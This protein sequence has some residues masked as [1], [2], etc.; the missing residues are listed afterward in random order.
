M[1]RLPIFF[2]VDVSESMIG[3]PI[4]QVQDGV[5]S[6]INELRMDPYALETAFVSVIAFAGKAK[7]LTPLT[8]LYKFYPPKFPIGGGTSLG[9]ALE[10][11]MDDMDH[12]V[13]KTTVEE[14]GDWKPI[15]FLF[16]DGNPTD[17]TQ[18]AFA[19]WNAKYRKGCNLI[20][21]SLGDNVNTNLLGQV[22]DNVLR[23]NDTTPESFKSFFK[24]VTAS[25]KTSSVSVT[26]MGD[27]DVKLAPI[28]GINLEKVDTNKPC[29][30]D[31]NFVVLMGKCQTTQKPYLIKYAKRLGESEIV[32]EQFV[33]YY[34][35]VGAYPI[36]ENTYSELS[37]EGG[38]Q[39][40][41]STNEIIGQPTC[42]CCG[43]QHGLVICEC[44]N[45]F[46]VGEDGHAKCPW[47][48]MDGELGFVGEGGADLNRTKG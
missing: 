39:Q 20:V 12:S 21:V 18:K 11:L 7:V 24:W 13:Q 10:F 35:L 30:V 44:G 46:C 37:E 38:R 42:P 17:D 4:E 43:N 15:I 14:K 8:E 48:G 5:A 19:R 29:I 32:P 23:L 40:K 22:S 2:L 6:I 41:V 3:T 27:D 26:D 1:R 16:T 45:I 47:C 33:S 31:E 9:N 25:I 28:D 34:K 36:D